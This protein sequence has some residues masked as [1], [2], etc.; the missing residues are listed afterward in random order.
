VRLRSGLNLPTAIMAESLIDGRPAALSDAV[1]LS[2]K[3]LAR[4]RLPLITGM[5]T[6]AAGARAAIRL[7]ERL[8][9]VIDHACDAALREIAAMREGHSMV[10]SPM[11]AR[12]RA[13]L[14][15]LVG[16][17]PEH[18]KSLLGF[19][20]EP[21]GRV[22]LAEEGRRREAIA[23][24][25]GSAGVRLN[26]ATTY[27]DSA[28]LLPALAELRAR[29]AGR[30]ARGSV[31][32]RERL[33]ELSARL[34]AA[35]FGVAVWSPAHL[36]ELEIEMLSALVDDLNVAT[37]WST[38]P[39]PGPA[40]ALGVNFVSTWL[41]GYPMRT[42]FARGKAEHDPWRFAARRLAE[43][44]EADAI[45]WIDALGSPAPDWQ[46]QAPIIAVAA[47]PA[48][49]RAD[50]TIMVGRP[51]RDHDGVLFDERLGALATIA[52]AAP[53]GRPSVAQVVRQ[54]AGALP[55]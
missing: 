41:C 18:S 5:A 24:C 19:L 40:N 45:L 52:A 17:M 46:A 14:I 29:I 13:D 43:S 30:P 48:D 22:Q 10:V 37:R 35:R 27:G 20:L 2:A 53:S 34:V 51:G 28:E 32:G 26:V 12:A 16:P 25:A 8:G 15:I 6:D 49:F 4:S 55:C 21:P 9:G 42:G 33:D 54:I 50:V 44:G 23:L 36:G 47:V 3:I 38:V 7:A 11:E 31:L 1:E 39:L